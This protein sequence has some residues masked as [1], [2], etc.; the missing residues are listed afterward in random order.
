MKRHFYDLLCVG[1]FLFIVAIFFYPTL[2]SGKLPIPSDALVGLYHPWRDLYADTN[3]RGVPFKN[4][5]TTDPVRQQ[6][7]WRKIAIDQWKKGSIP[8]WNPY[9]FSGVPLAANIQT[10][11]FY[12][13]NIIF[14]IFPF[15]TAWTLLI[16]LEPVLAGF[17]LYVYLRH[18]SLRPSVSLFGAIAWSFS[19]FNIA[20]FTWGTMVHVVLW[21]P[22]ILLSVDKV[23]EEKKKRFIWFILLVFSLTCQ[24]L[25][26]H[27]QLSLYVL[28]VAFGYMVWHV[29]HKKPYVKKAIWFIAAILILFLITSLQWAPF[30][31]LL[32]ESSRFIDSSIWL[33][34][35]WFLP[36]QHL[37]QFIVPD[38]FG[39]PTTLN[40]WG[41]W[42][43]GEF[44][45][46]I[47]IT[48][49]LF[50]LYS[51]SIRDRITTF[52]K[53]LFFFTLLFI[54][55]TPI[56]KIPYQF[57]I[58]I[59]SSLQPTR[60][61][62]II[63][64]SLI[65]LAAVGLNQWLERK[66]KRRMWL[67]LGFMGLLFLI[68]WA[69]VLLRNEFSA[70][71]LRNGLSVARR[72][73]ILPSILF[74]AS[75]VIIVIF[76][77]FH[78]KN[79]IQMLCVAGFIGLTGFDLLRFGWKFIPFTQSSYFFP[80]TKSLA[81][82]KQQAKPFRVM[83]L[84]DRIF[85]PNT[86]AYYGIESI[87][88][89]DPIYLERYEEFI[90]VSERGKPDIVPPFGFNRIITPHNVDSPL[91]PLLNVNYVISLQEVEKPYLKKVFQEGETRIYRY[92][93]SFPRA[94]FVENVLVIPQ[95]QKIFDTLF[96]SSF[97]PRK[98]A[99]AE[100][101]IDYSSHPLAINDRVNIT[102]YDPSSIDLDV[103]TQNS[104]FLVI[105]N[106]LYPGWKATLDEKPVLLHRANYLFMGL[107]I[108]PGEHK[109]ALTY[110][111]F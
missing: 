51:I 84:D 10:A 43:Y 7:P 81:F 101:Q 17:F 78:K 77:V 71:V 99:V 108:P 38:F 111:P 29:L 79:A 28:F 73:L 94:Y 2:I 61:M 12:P 66:D 18:V 16:I 41:V 23:L 1:L 30:I 54:L 19:G 35:G 68:V 59:L 32:T 88:G 34:E 67:T 11:A 57:E 103:H 109:V 80:E 70:E 53:L 44:I 72:N 39:N 48:P 97:N 100:E 15:T 47:G 55:P 65:M 76:G 90:A 24:L 74:I 104:Q 62:M 83:N 69:V 25:A 75:T 63:D 50:A 5:L 21:L 107:V 46:F 82:L 110:R 49:L 20:W 56:A 31:Q 4:F 6:I 91:I 9:S 95:K 27:A 3:P 89:Y 98:T 93:N 33:K 45:G 52:W 58:P 105:S 26:G 40:Y 13:L 37:V 102:A 60:L 96:E 85:P 14:F 86:M 92:T 106:I 87:E 8:F 64:F 22:L 42:N 36:W